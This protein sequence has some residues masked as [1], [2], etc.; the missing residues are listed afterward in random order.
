M[1]KARYRPDLAHRRAATTPVGGSTAADKAHYVD[2]LLYNGQVIRALTVGFLT[3]TFQF[4]YNPRRI[5][6]TYLTSVA[7]AESAY[8]T[9]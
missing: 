7:F 2:P 8:T 1:K 9:L 6:G 3:I 5:I 4:C